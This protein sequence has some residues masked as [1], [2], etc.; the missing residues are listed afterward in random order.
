M[1]ENNVVC[2]IHVTGLAR[3]SSIQLCPLLRHLVLTPRGPFESFNRNE[4]CLVGHMHPTNAKHTGDSYT[5]WHTL[6]LRRER[7]SYLSHTAH[8]P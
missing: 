2:G 4:L 1:N 3:T 8:P 5:H 6:L 7:A